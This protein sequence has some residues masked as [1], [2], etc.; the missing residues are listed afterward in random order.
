MPRGVQVNVRWG[1]LRPAGR[2]LSLAERCTPR[3]V[4]EFALGGGADADPG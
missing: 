4:A 2:P 3:L 1:H